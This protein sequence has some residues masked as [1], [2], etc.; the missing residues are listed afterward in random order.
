[1]FFENIAFYER[2][3][4]DKP[5]L[6]QHLRGY[7]VGKKWFEIAWTNA[8][9]EF[10]KLDWA[11][12]QT[13]ESLCGEACWKAN[14]FGNRLRLGRCIRYFAD[15]GILPIQVANPGKKGKRKYSRNS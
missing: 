4:S 3:G 2:G 11:K 5:G 14:G 7:W 10:S 15:E 13:T 12:P 1:M 8:S 9:V 6:G